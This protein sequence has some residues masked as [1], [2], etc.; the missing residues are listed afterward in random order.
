MQYTTLGRTN[1]N[2]SVIG[3]G[4]GGPSRL[5]QQGQELD[6]S[7]VDQN[8]INLVRQ[9][10]DAGVNFIDT[11][12]AYR[13]EQFVGEGMKGYDRSQ[14][15]IST[16]KSCRAE[17]TVKDMEDALEASLRRLNTDYIDI[18]NLHGVKPKHYAKDRDKFVP[19]LQRFQQEGKIRFLGITE[20]FNTDLDHLMLKA[21]LADGL[22]DVVM[23]GFNV[24][25]QSAREDVFGTTI[26]DNVGTQIMFA[27][28]R[29]LSRPDKLKEAVQQLVELG[30]LDPTEIDV[31]NP[32]GFLVNEGHAISIV[33]AAY[34]FCRD[35]PGAHVILSGTGNPTHLAANI[36]SLNAPPLP[37]DV[38][39]RLRHI[40]RHATA[41]TGE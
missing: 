34:R 39:A 15:V 40:F 26:T 8:S 1:L 6:D 16:K 21:A 27:V 14:I 10:L 2:V 13:T 3:L 5:G 41:V 18:Y 19:T 11:A 25:Q 22:W 31:N 20:H 28:R 29:A 35:E 9:A 12:E 38:T 23:V 33:D 4:C 24:L 17:T 36:K 32:L 37:D 30:Q 7:A